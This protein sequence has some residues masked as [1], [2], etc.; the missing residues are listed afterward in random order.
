MNVPLTTQATGTPGG[1]SRPG[2]IELDGL[3]R[4]FGPLTAV[5][6]V[7]LSVAQG[8]VF[9]LVGPNGAGKTTALKMLTTLL[10]P[11]E[12][13][14]RVAGFDVTRRPRE[15]RRRIGYVPQLLSADGGLTGFENLMVFARLYDVP[16]R[17]RRERIRDALATM[18]LEGS[19]DTP[20]KRYSGGMIRRLEIAQAFLHR[21]AVLFLDEPTVGLDPVARRGVWEDIRRLRTRY[22]T[23]VL[24]TT[25]YLEEADELC[26]ELAVMNL[27]RVVALGAPADLK[28]QT[29]EG[30]T[31]ED[32]FVHFTGNVIET[33]GTYRDAARTRR[34]ARRLG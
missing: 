16:R 25:H 19:A 4:R 29:G 20:V 3:T 17:E 34:T 18:G 32:A 12:G 14:A 6:H 1:T 24:L 13:S 9:G 30:A 27:G 2:A 8:N 5:D 33:G 22:G 7:T 28:A 11:S 21:P 15:V 26:D 31:L 23:T 10:P